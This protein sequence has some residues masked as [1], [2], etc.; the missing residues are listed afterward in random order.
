MEVMASEALGCD[1][2]LLEKM[3]VNFRRSPKTIY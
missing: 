1:N 3:V 2:T